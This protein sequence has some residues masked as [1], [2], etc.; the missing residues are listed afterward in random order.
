MS[1]RH[2]GRPTSQAEQPPCRAEGCDKPANGAKGFCRTHY[3][4]MRRGVID[5]D[6]GRRTRPLLRV[7]R[8]EEGSTCLI[9][10]C[11]GKPKSRGMCN[12]HM[13][14]REAGIISPTGEQL[15]ELLPTGRKRLRDRWRSSTRDGYILVV[16]PEGH[17]HSRAD[18]SLLEHRHVLEQHLGRYLEEWE[19]VHHKNGDRSDNRLENLE[20]LDGRARRGVGHPPG[21]AYTEDQAR[22]ALEHLRVN[23]PEAYNRIVEGLH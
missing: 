4:Y 21:S 9:P 5:E 6:T 20:L 2:P 16:A 10:G 17:P 18:G 1:N 19:I 23:D 12:R 13:M 11:E 15:R 22:A 3:I 14:Q 8:Y 7:R